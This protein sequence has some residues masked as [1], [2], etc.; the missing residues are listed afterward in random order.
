[1][2][3]IRDCNFLLG[4]AAPTGHN[5]APPL[6]MVMH[7]RADLHLYS[8]SE[9]Q[10]LYVMANK[11]RF[12]PVRSMIAHWQKMISGKS[13]TDMTSLVTRIARYVKVME[14]VE[15]TFLPETE[16]YRYEV[17]LEHF[18][19]GHMMRER[20]REFYLYVLPRVR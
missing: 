15:V 7:P 11:I 19:Q 14:G 8:L 13:P 3:V 5:V 10:Y 9:L 1:M 20:A 2:K 18:V 12:S 16:A 17:S 4:A 6:A